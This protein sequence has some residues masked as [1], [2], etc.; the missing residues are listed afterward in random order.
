M[1]FSSRQKW[2][3]KALLLLAMLGGTVRAER[4]LVDQGRSHYEIVCPTNATPAA[5]MA[6]NELRVWVKAST[7]VQLPIVQNPSKEAAHIFV[8]ENPWST[9]AGV[10]PTEL[11][12]EGY[13]LRTIG[14]DLHIV[15]VDVL[16]GSLAPKRASATQTGT[17]S[18]VYD[19]LERSLGILFLWHDRLGTVIPPSDHAVIPDLDLH[20]SPAWTYRMLAYSPEGM[21]GEDIFARKLRLGHS[22]TVT[23]SHAW[24]II[25]PIEK[26][27]ATHPDW[28]AEIDGK[29]QPAYYMERHG[30]QVCTNNPEVIDLFAK[31]AIEFFNQQPNRDMFSVS[32]NDGSG[33][34]TCLRCRAL[35]NGQR[36]DG[37]PILTDRLITFYNAIAE[38]VA[39]VH[40]NKLLGAYAYSYYREAPVR[41]VPH[42]NLYLV[43]ATNT[44]FHQ[45][46]GWPEEH[47]TEVAWRSKAKHLAKYDIYYSP[48]SS[49]N[50][51]APITQHLTEKVRAESAVGIEGGYLYM[52]QSYEQLGAGHWLLA[53][54]MWDPAADAQALAKRYYQGLYGEAATAVQAYYDLLEARLVAT[55]QAPLDLSHPAIR[56]ALRK[57]PGIGSPAYILAA[58]R[59]VLEQATK[60]INAAKVCRLSQEESTRLQRLL[61]QHE[62][63]I[64][65]VEGMFAA[66]R[67][68]ADASCTRED[69]VAFMRWVERRQAARTRISAFAPSL[70]R[71]LESG[72]RAE[73][74][75]L[76]PTGPLAHFARALLKLDRDTQSA[77]HL[78]HGDFEGLT[79]ANVA[80]RLRWNATGTATLELQSDAPRAG[81]Q[82]V[83]VNVPE[84]STGAI[85]LTATVKPATAYR[86]TLDHWNDPSPTQA[87]QGD[88]ADA[89]T[90]GEAPIAPR[91][92]VIFR[93]SNGKTVAKNHWSGIGAAEHI[94]SWHTFPHLFETPPDAQQI[95]FTIFLQQ[96]GVYQ[97]DEVKIEAL[98]GG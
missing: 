20:T 81:R 85:T 9:A 84:S 87:Q 95:S 54:L 49:L 45:G 90:R 50:L 16:R 11:K 47:E 10:T 4:V 76:A 93:D 86:I 18:G 42:P 33:F 12:P 65:T 97:L 23:H 29:R 88:D 79:Q 15:G 89:I 56:I 38:R 48:D 57:H 34:C 43:H 67:L 72:D 73:T 3:S 71:N 37:R 92:R 60:L 77:Q 82:S 63:L 36:S 21:A 91:T 70:T 69:A 61:D 64:T 6:A 24:H 2:P 55:K 74:E 32:P 58:Y 83:R 52:G 1:R 8:G 44:A 25:A 98:G 30:G 96:P 62:L 31:A 46:V 53:H 40:P 7:Q 66:G 68:E 19:F 78:N 26:Y 28:Y 75:A 5:L 41:V 14:E 13:V 27:G 80:A 17:L 35:D 39:V 59:P 22:Y 94:K 51:I